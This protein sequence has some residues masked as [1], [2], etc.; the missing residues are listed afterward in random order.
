MQKW[1]AFFMRN[2]M[3]AWS[4]IRRTDVPAISGKTAQEI[5]TTPSSYTAGD[6]IIP[7]VNY[8]QA[9]GLAKRVP[10]PQNARRLNTNTPAAKLMSDRVFWD[11][12]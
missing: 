3:E 10:Y 11:A 8:I 7:A 12:H 2:H 9:G 6:M 5:Y 4:E 1:A